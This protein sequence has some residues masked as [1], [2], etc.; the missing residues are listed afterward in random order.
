MPS[1]QVFVVG[2]ANV[3]FCIY[4]DHA[5][6]LG[7]TVTGGR[8][9]QAFGGKG[10]NQAVAAAR[11]GAAV[12]FGG[13]LGNDASAEQYRA[14]LLAE[15]IDLAHTSACDEPTGCALI[16]INAAGENSIAVASGANTTL[17]PESLV[18]MTETLRHAEL[19]M[20]QMELPVAATA[21]ALGLAAEHG[22][23]VLF[24]YA[25]ICDGPIPVTAAMTHLV[26]NAIE[27]GQLLG[28]EPV[29]PDGAERAAHLLRERGPRTVTI[30]L[31][32]EGLVAVDYEKTH[33]LS[34]F[35][36]EVIDTTAAG[37]TFCGYLAAGLA[38]KR[39]FEDSLSRANAA[40]AIAVGRP[41]AQPSI[42]NQTDLA[43]FA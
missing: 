37:D 41:G 28:T 30:T 10:A 31:G 39:S 34:A 11:A 29:T 43:D 7:E 36:V 17:T 21:A 42:P 19:L 18:S 32:G 1:S 26:V 6:V 24:N 40:A 38:Q 8:F 3:D 9:R 27:A 13:R 23:D 16:T 22:V 25:P 12:A 2:S 5:P 20:L 14:H 33:R 35:D 15:G 4:V